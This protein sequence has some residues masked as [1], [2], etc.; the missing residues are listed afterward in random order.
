MI[1]ELANV[2]EKVPIEQINV[3]LSVD[4]VEILI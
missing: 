1:E 3:W 2:K 4:L